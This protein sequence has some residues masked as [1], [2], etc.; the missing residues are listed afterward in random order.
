MLPYRVTVVMN[1]ALH[2]CTRVDSIV[3]HS[4]EFEDGS[5]CRMVQIREMF[6][7]EPVYER[8]TEISLVTNNEC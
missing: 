2:T 7:Y 6:A 3:R 4:V 1:G 8:S 5:M